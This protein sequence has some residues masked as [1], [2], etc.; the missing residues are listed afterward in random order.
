MRTLTGNA[1]GSKRGGKK[2]TLEEGE[3]KSSG[4]GEGTRGRELAGRWWKGKEHLI[5][6][7]CQDVSSTISADDPYR[8]HSLSMPEPGCRPI[9]VLLPSPSLI[10]ATDATQTWPYLS[11]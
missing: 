9:H 2:P 11:T 8:S 6:K 10:A 1:R 4:S 5:S 7:Y 3:R